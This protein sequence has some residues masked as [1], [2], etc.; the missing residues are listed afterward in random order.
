MIDALFNHPNH[1]AA[2]QLLDVTVLRHEAIA[3]NLANL[4]TPNY[5]RLDVSKDFEQ[6]LQESISTGNVRRLNAMQPRISVDESAVAARRDGNTVD[7]EKEL[8][9]MS[10]N[11]V[12]HAVETHL[13][14]GRLLKL[15]LA[16]TGRAA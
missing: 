6:Q 4:E 14:T 8:V 11:G 3:G 10:R 12:E 1:L 9:H 16:I 13:I 7:L 5:K 15:R 2:K